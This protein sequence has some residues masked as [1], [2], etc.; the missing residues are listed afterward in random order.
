[1]GTLVDLAGMQFG[2]LLV[3]KKSTHGKETR[4]Y[5]LCRCE[6]GNE[7]IVS[8]RY[9]RNGTTRSCG[10]LI[11]ERS[12]EW[13]RSAEFAAHRVA[14][15]T[16]HGHKRRG[17]TSPEYK[18]WLGMK[19][20]CYDTKCKDYPNWGGR[21]IRVSDDWNASFES[22]LRDM[23]PRPSRRHQIDRR[24]PE[25]NYEA[26][27]CRWVLPSVQASE[28]RRD[29]APVAVDGVVYPSLA[30]ACRHFGV[31][32]TTALYRIAAGDPREIAVSMSGRKSPAR[33]RESYL[34]KNHPDRC[35][36]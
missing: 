3:L 2:K 14:G 8:G 26:G 23:G 10:C 34:P 35:L 13:M 36:V 7:T 22:F 12:S 15:N 11:R 31:N 33:T 24:D 6:C 17:Q 18:T 9:L 30:A 21:G 28:N 1:M 19:R 4:A 27:N 20:R 5:W 25:G 29:I 32:H 16:L